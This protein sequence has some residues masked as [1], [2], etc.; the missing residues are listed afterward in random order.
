MTAPHIE[1]FIP[2]Y[3]CEKWIV[4]TLDSVAMQ[5]YPDEHCTIVDDASTDG[6]RKIINRELDR[7]PGDW[8]VIY[9]GENR[10]MPHNLVEIRDGDPDDVIFLLDGD[11]Y[12]P[13][14]L[15]LNLVAA[16]F[17]DPELWLTY[18][19]YTREDP[20]HMPNPAVPYPPEIIE[21]ANFRGF[22][23]I[24]LLYNHPLVFRRWLLNELSD[25]ELQDDEGEWFTRCYDHVIMMPML[26]LAARGHFKWLP[27][28]LYV[29]NEENPLS[30]SK[31]DARAESDRIHR[32]INARPKREAL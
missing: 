28:V 26:E 24:S 6:T 32:Q 19:S 1:V 31:D 27:E 11:D 18:G 3:N 2:A 4:R 12:L 14:D 16:Q 7:L 21:A 9:N 23:S 15:V 10:K 13:H 29:Y 22:S 17:D 25:A 30:E 5:M 8:N 20:T